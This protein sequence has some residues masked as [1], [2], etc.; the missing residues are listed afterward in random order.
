MSCY[1]MVCDDLSEYIMVLYSG[2]LFD[3][4]QRET[5]SFLTASVHKKMYSLCFNVFV[6]FYL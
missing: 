6:C 5:A 4:K 3:T 1:T 2:V